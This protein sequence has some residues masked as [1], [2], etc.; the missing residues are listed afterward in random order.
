MG[1]GANRAA[2]TSAI[3][4][5]QAAEEAVLQ[6][7]RKLLQASNDFR[8]AQTAPWQVSLVRARAD[9]ADAQVLQ[10][11]AQLAQAESNLSYTVIRSPVTGIIGKKAVELGQNV[12]IGQELVEVV[13]LDDV[14]VTANFK[15]RQLAHMRQGQPVQIRVDAYGRAW[16]AHIT[17]IG[18]G[19]GSVRLLPPENATGNS[20]KVIQRIPVRIDFDRPARQVF[21]AEG[22]LK[23]GLSVETDVRGR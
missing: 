11:N 18:V 10:R 8:V 3:A 17:N 20:V 23:P 4:G 22:L 2:V 5:V 9:A 6:A 12:S 15:E 14:W 21:N 13:P 19:T 1:F 7:Q 16:N